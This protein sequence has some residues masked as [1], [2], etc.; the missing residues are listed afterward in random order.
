[1]AK[2]TREPAENAGLPMKKSERTRAAILEASLTA[3]AE[4]GY[5][6][7]TV[8]DIAA[9]AG[10]DPALVVRYFGSKEALFAEASDFDLKLPDLTAA[11]PGRLGQVLIAHFLEMILMRTAATNEEA[12]GKMRKIFAGQVMPALA[13]T[14]EPAEAATRAGLVSTQLLGLALCRYVLKLPPVT[15]LSRDQIV[16]SVGAS[17]QT[18][19][20]GKL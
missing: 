17:L 20:T 5:E 19:V 16:K 11:K 1:M 15:A 18:Y 4:Q 10:V 13:R 2:Q 3:F 9:R 14:M 6:R 7:A 8:R 12:A